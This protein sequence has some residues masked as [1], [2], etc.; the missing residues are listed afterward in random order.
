ML[1][2]YS[3]T[4]IF[5]VSNCFEKW[6]YSLEEI[7]RKIRNSAKWRQVLMKVIKVDQN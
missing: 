1:Y 5:L 2:T 3:L 6:L 7:I 4:A